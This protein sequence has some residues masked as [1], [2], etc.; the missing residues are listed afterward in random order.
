MNEDQ[1]NNDE[2]LCIRAEA[3]EYV[4]GPVLSATEAGASLRTA[5]LLS[6]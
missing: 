6:Y 4:A 5:R 3:A 1:P 2:L